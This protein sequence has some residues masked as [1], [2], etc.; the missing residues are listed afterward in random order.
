VVSSLTHSIAEPLG[1]LL[2][3]AGF[4]RERHFALMDMPGGVPPAA[5]FAVFDRQ[6]DARLA[7][8]LAL[9][10]D[11]RT[12]APADAERAVDPLSIDQLI[13]AGFLEA[14]RSGLRSQVKLSA[15]SGVILAGDTHR[16]WGNT[17]FVAALSP[18][19]K[20][21]AHTTV[22]QPV[23][24]ALD[25]CTGS[26][27][28]ALLA[29]RH[30]ERVVGLDANP[31]ALEL[32]RLNQGLNGVDNVT[33]V[34]GDAFEP[35]K[36]QRFD[37][38]VANPPVVIS[39][40]NTV[41]ARDSAIGGERLSRQIVRESAEHLNEGGFATVLCNWG[42]GADDGPSEWVAG[43]GC[44]ALLLTFQT[45]EPLAYAMANA[46]GP[47]GGDS[48]AMTETVKRWMRH[49][50]DAGLERLSTGVIVLR[51]RSA[52]PNWV[53]EFETR[54]EP[55]GA[56]GDQLERMFAGG[57]F[58]A[59]PSD[60][61]QL[62]KLLGAT[63]HLA[64]GHRLDQGLIYRNGTYESGDAVLTQESGMNLPAHVDYR[65]VPAVVGCDGR[66]RLADV[67]GETPI[68]EGLDQPAFHSLCLAA[69]RDLI[70]RG[71][72]VAGP[73]R[74]EAPPAAG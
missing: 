68:P 52:G 20:A 31:H 28:Q 11:G 39:P 45:L 62:G 36:G 47:Q 37:L 5:G 29:A 1:E 56:G 17:N 6:E 41:L 67:L 27:T 57:D 16:E 10:H 13:E 49:Y 23:R 33:W 24:S 35:V 53:R 2:G 12:L 60:A 54:G 18:P 63:W 21:V 58:L 34:E 32:A 74:A 38:V 72:L 15:I 44:D 9:F 14:D 42:G 3:E 48:A 65:I 70:A 66:R 73:V 22:R 25:V 8:L 59:G 4:G 43:L 51:R 30:A 55:S 64:D 40:D 19:G 46:A 7:T 50:R 26:G 69:I 61:A 71:F